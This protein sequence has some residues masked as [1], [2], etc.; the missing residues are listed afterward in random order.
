MTRDAVQAGITLL[1]TFML[2][3]CTLG[4]NSLLF[5][6]KSNVGMD[7]D[8]TPPTAEISIARR[9]GVVGPTFEKGQTPPVLASFRSER[10]G[11]LGVFAGVS[12]TFAGGD[13]AA[14]MTKLFGG[15]DVTQAEDATLCLT[16]QP[17]PKV[18]GLDIT[19]PG[20]GDVQP[21]LFGT[22]TS[23]GLKIAWSGL[24]AQYPDTMRLGYHRKEFAL[25]PVFGSR[26]ACGT[27]SG[28]YKVTVPS[29]LATVDTYATVKG[30]G[31]ATI[32]YLQYFATGVA[33]TNLALRKDVREAMLKRLDPKATER[34]ERFE[35]FTKHQEL[36]IRAVED[37]QNAYQQ[38]T[39]QA[40]RTAVRNEAINLKLVPNGTTD[41]S[42]NQTLFK[43]VDGNKPGLA[44]NLKQL[45]NFIE[46]NS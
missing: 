43:I 34:L 27:V 8:T 36:Q 19:F 7:T 23:F 40:K 18:L 35:S 13:A 45:K 33:A 42:F 38:L 10:R 1:V 29:F 31:D 9:E 12:S 46:N 30:P 37:I 20:S 17:S 26:E 44:D 4:Y 14:T 11:I 28:V 24:T 5:I 6:T 15:T 21:L 3:G 16:Q 22:D 32:Q 41:A 39:D 2:G 25:A